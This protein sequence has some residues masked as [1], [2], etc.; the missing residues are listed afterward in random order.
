ME[1]LNCPFLKKDNFPTGGY[2]LLVAKD[3]LLKISH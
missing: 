1:K 3:G 2:A